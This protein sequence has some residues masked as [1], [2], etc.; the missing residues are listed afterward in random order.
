MAAHNTD[1]GSILLAPQVIAADSRLDNAVAAATLKRLRTSA[2]ATPPPTIDHCSAAARISA[3]VLTRD[4]P[5]LLGRALDSLR[6]GDTPVHTIV[7]DNASSPDA[8]QLV[9][10]ECAAREDVELQRAERNLGCAGGRRLGAELA[11][12]ELVLFL[13]DDAELMPGALE[14]MVADLDGHPST[15]AVSATVVNSNGTVHHSGGSLEFGDEIATFGL[16]GAG[17]R[18]APARLPASGPA[19]WVPGTAALVRHDLL[20]EFPIDERMVGSYEDNEWCYRVAS[21]RPGCFRRSRE[22][23]V[24]HRRIEKPADGIGAETRP[25]AIRYLT[26]HAR[27]YQRHGVLL[28]P[29]LFDLMSQLRAQDG[30]CDVAAARLLLELVGSKGPR[31][32]LKAW[33]DGGLAVLLDAPRTRTELRRAE[34]GLADARAEIADLKQALR[35]QGARMDFLTGRHE[36]LCRVEQGGWWRLRGRLLPVMRVASR[37]RARLPG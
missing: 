8:A 21:E 24:L 15:G 29:S 2:R 23:L 37:I 16:I 31:W 32:T 5:G 1:A 27:F 36:A 6:L 12:G 10:A 3:V 35:A 11:E 17:R 22:A 30:T 34:N 4:R 19:G 7:V 13:D 28:G 33:S 20:I 9:A 25:L 14:H 18:F 26:A